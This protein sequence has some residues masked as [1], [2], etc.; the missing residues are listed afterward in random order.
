MGTVGQRSSFQLTLTRINSFDSAFGTKFYYIF[1][2]VN[3]NVFKWGTTTYL[4]MDVGDS[5]S[6]KGTIKEHNEYNNNKQ[7]ELS[8]CK[9]EAMVKAALY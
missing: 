4:D 2:D 9:V 7:T 5:V 1:A 6:L 8:R 3:G